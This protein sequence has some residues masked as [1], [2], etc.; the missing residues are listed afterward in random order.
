MESKSVRRIRRF[1]SALLSPFLLLLCFFVI[2]I[3]SA[4]SPSQLAYQVGLFPLSGWI[5]ANGEVTPFLELRH[6]W[7]S[8]TRNVSPPSQRK[9]HYIDYF[10][11]QRG[12]L[13][14]KEGLSLEQQSTV[15]SDIRIVFRSLPNRGVSKPNQRTA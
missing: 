12:R 7:R 5:V 14:E 3:G 11:E 8:T 1:A 13:A 10:A 2:N 15:R 6:G 9:P 4:H